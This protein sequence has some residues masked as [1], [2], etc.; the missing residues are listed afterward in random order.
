MDRNHAKKICLLPDMKMLDQMVAIGE[1][2]KIASHLYKVGFDSAGLA[3][4]LKPGHFLQVAVTDTYDPFL[5]RPYTIYRV[6]G[7]R[8]E[9]LYHVVG[10]GSDILARKKRGDTLKVMGPLGNI[11][12]IN[13]N[14]I[15]VVVG[16]GIGIAPFIFLGQKMRIDHFLMGARSK[17][18]LLPRAEVGALWKKARFSTEDGSAGTQGFITRCLEEVIRETKDAKR[19]YL[20]ACGPTPMMKAVMQMAAKYG[21][22][23]EASVEERM[24]CG[25]GACLGCVAETRDGYKTSCVE[26]T[27]FTFDKLIL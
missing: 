12:K 15:N 26:G 10:R 9:I 1:N 2:T 20:Y 8:L 24:A 25:V 3:K 5:R 27:V 16:G 23:G 14:R 11:F 19:I 21:I 6:K 7:S 17:D 18:G 13:K 4:I 22:E